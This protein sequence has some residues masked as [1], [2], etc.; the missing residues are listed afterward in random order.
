[1]TL[2]TYEPKC[3]DLVYS[4]SPCRDLWSMY[5]CTSLEIIRLISNNAAKIMINSGHNQ[6]IHLKFLRY[7]KK[8]F[9]DNGERHSSIDPE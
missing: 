9:F 5:L 7:G 2:L 6:I 3:R 4:V 1:M 8:S